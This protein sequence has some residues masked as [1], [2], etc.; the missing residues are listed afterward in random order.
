MSLQYVN[1]NKLGSHVVRVNVP[2]QPFKADTPP[3]QRRTF[4]ERNDYVPNFHEVKTAYN[5][6]N[7][8]PS[9]S[10]QYTNNFQKIPYTQST[11]ESGIHGWFRI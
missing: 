7:E 11:N 5:E 6:G 10:N 2:T 4:K 9:P 8:K 1:D 3:I